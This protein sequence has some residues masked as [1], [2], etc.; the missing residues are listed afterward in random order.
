[1]LTAWEKEGTPL[2][3]WEDTSRLTGV[4]KTSL[5]KQEPEICS[6]PTSADPICPFPN[7]TTTTTTTTTTTA[8]TTTTNN[9]TNNND[10]N[11]SCYHDY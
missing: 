1:M 10:N 4:P 6:G 7:P 3:F 9:N 2:L 11:N 8:T 5:C